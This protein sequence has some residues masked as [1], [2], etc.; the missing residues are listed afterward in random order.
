[1]IAE[2][3]PPEQEHS[4]ERL[5]VIR[6][7]GARVHNLKNVDLDITRGRLTVITGPSGSGKS[8]LAFDTLFAEGQRQY[9]ETLSNY[10]RQFLNQLERPDVDLIDGLQPTICIDQRPGSHNPRSTVATVTELYD[11][12]R[13]LMA[14]LGETSCYACG[15]RVEQ[16]T[17]DQIEDQLLGMPEGTKMMILAP[18]VRG[19]RGQ[20]KEVVAQIRKAGFVR[21]RIDGMVYELEQVPELEARKVHHMDAVVDRI[22]VRP[23]IEA[24]IAESIQLAL[25]HGEGLMLICYLDETQVSEDAPQ[26]VWRDELFSTKCAC[27]ACGISYE[28]IEPRTFSFNSPYGACP[29]CEGLGRRREFDIELVIP[30]TTLAPAT[31]AFAPWKSCKP[32]QWRKTRETL[33]AFAESKGFSWDRPWSEWTPASQ[34]RMLR[35]EGKKFLGLLT[36]LEKEYATA[37]RAERREELEQYRADVICSACQGSRLRPAANSVR[38]AGKNMLELTR[39]NVSQ[40]REFFGGLT[41]PAEQRPIADPLLIEIRNRLEFLEKVGVDYLSLNRSADTLSGGELQRVRLATSIGSALIGVC[42]VLDEPSIG[43]HPRD[44][45]RLI[46]AL[47]DLQTQGNSVVVV[48]HDEATMRSADEIIDV[49]PRAGSQGGRIVAQGTPE[50]IMAREDSVTGGYLRGRLRIPKFPSVAAPT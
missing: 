16:L 26:G 49:G 41:F 30:N 39:M 20:H 24:R 31:G 33:E 12:L 15:A 21:A 6:I 25:K 37:T 1:M 29:D 44:N 42:Y 35:G 10:A 18:L 7:R 11:Y 32:S 13:I 45:D 4:P 38:L 40:A 47:R 48:E 19:R 23:G 2:T 27:P 14:R 5:P 43:L 9:I 8:S 3:K 17:A 34:Q 36:L 46:G 28:E 50:Q 22:I